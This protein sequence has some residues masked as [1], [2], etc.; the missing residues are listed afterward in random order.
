MMINLGI[1]AFGSLLLAAWAGG[2]S[3]QQLV[4]VSA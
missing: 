4:H 2:D 1:A 3:D